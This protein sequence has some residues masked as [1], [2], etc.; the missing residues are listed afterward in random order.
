MSVTL[1]TLKNPCKDSKAS[2]ILASA[3]Q[4]SAVTQSTAFNE[5]LK[6]K[7]QVGDGGK[8][9]TSLFLTYT[10]EWNSN[11]VRVYNDSAD[12]KAKSPL[13]KI[14]AAATTTELDDTV[15][16]H[17]YGEMVCKKSLLRPAA[18]VKYYVPI[19]DIW[20]VF[21]GVLPSTSATSYSVITNN[22]FVYTHDVLQVAAPPTMG[23]TPIPIG[24]PV[25]VENGHDM[26][27]VGCI[28]QT[29]TGSVNFVPVL[30][31]S[32]GAVD[33]F[34]PL[35]I[36]GRKK[37]DI[38]VREYVFA[39]AAVRNTSSLV[40][41]VLWK[42]WVT[43]PSDGKTISENG[44]GDGN[45]DD[46]QDKLKF[47]ITF[48]IVDNVS[49]NVIVHKKKE[50]DVEKV[51]DNTH[52][53]NMLFTNEDKTHALIFKTRIHKPSSWL[54]TKSVLKPL[55]E[56][57]LDNFQTGDVVTSIELHRAEVK[58]DKNSKDEKKKNKDKKSKKDKKNGGKDSE[59]EDDT[60]DDSHREKRNP[61]Q[62]QQPPPPP[63]Q[64]HQ[65][66]PQQP[67][68][69]QQQ[70]QQH[71]PPPP[72]QQQQQ[73][74]P[75]RQPPQQTPQQPPQQTPQQPPSRQPPQQTPQLAQFPS[76]HLSQADFLVNDPK[77]VNYLAV[78]NCLNAFVKIMNSNTTNI[79][80]DT[81]DWLMNE[82]K[83][84]VSLMDT[85]KD[86]RTT[87][88]S[89]DVIAPSLDVI[90]QFYTSMAVE[91]IVKDPIMFCKTIECIF[92]RRELQYL[93]QTPPTEEKENVPP[94]LSP[95]S[96][97]PKRKMLKIKRLVVPENLETAEDFE[98]WSL[99]VSRKFKRIWLETDVLVFSQFKCWI[100]DELYFALFPQFVYLDFVVEEFGDGRSE[101]DISTNRLQA[102]ASLFCHGFVKI[103]S[104]TLFSY[105]DV[106]NTYLI[107]NVTKF[108]NY[109]D[110]HW[111]HYLDKENSSSV[112]KILQKRSRY[113]SLRLTDAGTLSSNKL[114]IVCNNFKTGAY[115]NI[116]Q[117]V[118][119]SYLS[120][121]FPAVFG[122]YEHACKRFAVYLMPWAVCALKYEIQAPLLAPGLN[123]NFVFV[124]IQIALF[125]LTIEG[126]ARQKDNT[127]C[128]KPTKHNRK[129]DNTLCSKPTIQPD[130]IADA[131]EALVNALCLSIYPPGAPNRID[132]TQNPI[133]ASSIQLDEQSSTVLVKIFNM[134]QEALT[135]LRT[136]NDRT[137]DNL[138]YY[139]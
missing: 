52:L 136:S 50:K 109:V 45:D 124:Q 127:L 115:T 27:L 48:V 56:G 102:I 23:Q 58:N 14:V 20:I 57:M 125:V 113:P 111:S 36:K 77:L 32:I 121:K 91:S 76:N 137:I 126:A 82:F 79:E 18:A 84:M 120:N 90:A 99:V 51:D 66:P 119:E 100:I 123:N 19:G 74:P 22:L 39:A 12:V 62:P 13:Y 116:L 55:H 17:V 10:I 24:S 108:R 43:L 87:A 83:N 135:T 31:P 129:K 122:K 67:P 61:Q 9:I 88:P 28:G 6:L 114:T 98:N 47:V 112:K 8:E 101:A 89:V 72:Q 97:P 35:H 130:T 68:P 34:M 103:K 105:L 46:D 5:L 41:K 3:W 132:F 71:Q 128:S 65:P 29:L 37:F 139:L 33:I 44:N 11:G 25:F 40:K 59:A 133:D 75:S 138:Q 118:I 134:L 106:V 110:G 30:G 86:R 15:Y 53:Y 104:T 85:A 73:Q 80:T 60:D 95:P 131:F 54:S 42:E 7:K 38:I 26:S 16:K 117:R 69:P 64:Q 21:D 1:K 92:A 78:F 49:V 96:S 2:T 93:H 94:P 107:H 4:Q 63:P 70:Q 81:F